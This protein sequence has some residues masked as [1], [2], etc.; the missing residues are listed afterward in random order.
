MSKQYA[1]CESLNLSPLSE[2]ARHI[3]GFH[4]H[5][6]RRTGRRKTMNEI[7]VIQNAADAV[8]SRQPS[9]CVWLGK[10]A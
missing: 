2:G 3:D 8:F 9:K 10:R 1:M 5:E 6:K 4:V 7:K